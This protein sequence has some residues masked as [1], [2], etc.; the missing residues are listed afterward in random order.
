MNLTVTGFRNNCASDKSLERF[1]IK[2]YDTSLLESSL[3]KCH[4]DLY[5][6]RKQV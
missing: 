3:G 4:P 1:R 6:F 5:Q 2:N